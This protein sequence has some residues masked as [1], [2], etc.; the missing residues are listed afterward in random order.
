MSFSFGETVSFGLLQISVPGQCSAWLFPQGL[1]SRSCLR[2]AFSG[3]LHLPSRQRGNSPSVYLATSFAKRGYNW[4]P[5][6]ARIC[7]SLPNSVLHKS[8]GLA[9]SLGWKWISERAVQAKVCVSAR[10][11]WVLVFPD[12]CSS[13]LSVGLCIELLLVRLQTPRQREGS[14]QAG[15]SWRFCGS[16]YSQ[17]LAGLCH[18]LHCVLALQIQ[19]EG[20]WGGGGGEKTAGTSWPCSQLL[21]VGKQPARLAAAAWPCARLLCTLKS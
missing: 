6:H 4:L 8:G 20:N 2:W 1:L 21:L 15:G 17:M 3:V 9:D 19:S 13:S 10:V 7:Y 5:S 14:A 11:W 18:S 16:R 12:A